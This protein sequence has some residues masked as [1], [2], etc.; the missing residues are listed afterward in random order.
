DGPVAVDWDN[1]ETLAL[2]ASDLESSGEPGASYSDCPAC[3]TKEK[4]YTTWEKGLK[5]WVRQNE[6]VSLFRSKKHRLT[7]EPG[8]SE[9]AFRARLQQAGSEKRDQAVAKLRKR[10]ASK[11][12]T[13]ENRLLRAEQSIER[14]QQQSSQ[15]KMDTAISVGTAILGA[16]LGRKRLS[17]TTAGRVGTAM[18]KAG[19]ARKEAADVARAKQTAKKVHA[20]LEALNEALAAEVDALDTAYDAQ[21]EELTEIP[22]RPKATDIHVPLIGLAW[23]PYR[24]HGDGRLKGA[25]LS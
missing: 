12:T 25:W 1:A 22:I 19:G 18:R 13:L 4:N 10:Y 16:V 8:E 20:E 6:T 15:K 17:T 11:A 21:T 23:M 14:E 7:S 2:T 9:G 24:D 3:A 5:R